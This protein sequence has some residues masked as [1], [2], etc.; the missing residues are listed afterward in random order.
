MPEDI[1]GVPRMGGRHCSDASRGGEPI[2]CRSL[3][4]FA[5]GTAAPPITGRQTRHFTRRLCTG[6]SIPGQ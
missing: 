6:S 1:D 2:M 4:A 5:L 3:M